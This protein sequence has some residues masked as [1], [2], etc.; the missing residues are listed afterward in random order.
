MSL[1]G[2]YVQWVEP[3]WSSHASSSTAA[4]DE[5]A[6]DAELS[7]LAVSDALSKFGR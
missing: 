5:R 4:R 2:L 3:G 1:D 7:G 6:Y